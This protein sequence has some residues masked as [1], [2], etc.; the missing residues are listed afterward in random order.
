MKRLEN[1]ALRDARA[2][3]RVDFNVPLDQDGSVVDDTRIRA[4]LPTL[5]HL[6]YQNAACILMTHL[7]RPGGKPTPGLSLKPVVQR[8]S[9]LLPE[10]EVRHCEEVVGPRAREMAESLRGGQVLVL[11]N[12][13][14]HPGEKEDDGD[15]AS[16]L[17]G[18]GQVYVNDAFAACHRTHASVHAVARRF[19][20]G[21][22]AVGF[23]VEHE[24]DVLG[25]LV[26]SP[27]RPFIALFGGA[28]VDDKL[29][30]GRALVDRVDRLLVGGAMAY[31]FLRARGVDVGA[32]KVEND[33]LDAARQILDRAGDKLV[34]PRDHVM[35]KGDEASD[36]RTGDNLDDAFQGLDIGPETASLFAREIRGAS[37]VVWNGPMGKIEDMRFLAGTRQVAQAMASSS[38]TTIVGGGET[39]EVVRRLGVQDQLT[40]VSTGGS[41]FLDYI[42]HGTLPALEVLRSD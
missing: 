24:L 20:P 30:A 6:C 29:K 5:H 21:H 18:L 1:L 7:G 37:T 26:D 2:L 10:H 17:A 28:K 34:L 41:A 4:S 14:F 23:L 15:F 19:E 31:T 40:H 35:A 8:L 27:R 32:S 42:A 36:A 25:T 11:E 12:L 33:Q 3:V 13:R 39:G 16:E 22:R 9:Q 38:A